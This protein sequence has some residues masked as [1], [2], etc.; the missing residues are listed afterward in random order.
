MSVYNCLSGRSTTGRFLKASDSVAVFG[1]GGLGLSCVMIASA[2]GVKQIIAI[3][4]TMNALEKALA[5]GATDIVNGKTNDVQ[6]RVLELTN[7]LGADLTLDAAGFRATCE[8]AISCTRRGGRMIQVGLPIGD[9]KPIVPMGMVAGK[10]LEIKGSHGAD[11]RD[12]LK[13][14]EL[15]EVGKL[16]PKKLIER[17][18]TLEQGIKAL[19]EMDNKSPIGMLMITQFTDKPQSKY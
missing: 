4:V 16:D 1:C 17:E 6:K 15:V 3:D 13:I 14:L 9:Q 8:D 10:E 5:V 2:F 11:A 7:G 12:I 18:V 19:M